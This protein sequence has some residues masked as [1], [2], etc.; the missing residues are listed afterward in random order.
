MSKRK[1]L[2]PEEKKK[3]EEDKARKKRKETVCYR[4]VYFCCI[5]G[6]ASVYNYSPCDYIGITGKRRP[7]EPEDCKKAGV[8]LSKKRKG[9]ANACC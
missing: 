1:K 5:G 9:R 2:T 7:C 4:C 3:Q 6:G 8:F